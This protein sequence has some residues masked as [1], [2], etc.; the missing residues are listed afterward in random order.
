MIYTLRTPIG[1]ELYRLKYCKEQYRVENIA[2]T[3]V[4]FLNKLKNKW[5]LDVIIP[6]PPSDTT[7]RFQPVYE[8][9]ELIGTLIGIPVQSNILRKIKSTFQLKDIDDPDKRMEILEGA[10]DIDFN[11]FLGKNVLIFDDL[12]RSGMT[13]NAICDIISNKANASNVYVL[14]ITKTRS[15]R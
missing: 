13:L 6:V 7:R 15:K 2:R 1:E 8:I 9:A 12:Y 14:T 3:A 4:D 11:S 10:F 5:L